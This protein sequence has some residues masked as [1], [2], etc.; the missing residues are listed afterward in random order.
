MFSEI[1]PGYDTSTFCITNF[2]YVFLSML[3]YKAIN[4]D[5]LYIIINSCDSSN[6][7]YAYTVELRCNEPLS[8]EVL[9]ITNY[10]LYLSNSKNNI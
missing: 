9:G 5:L 2:R 3:Y 8:N 6:L 1:V 7:N 4:D 10:F